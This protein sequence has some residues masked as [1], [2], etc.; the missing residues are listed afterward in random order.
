MPLKPIRVTANLPG[1]VEAAVIERIRE[2][3][4]PSVSAY[5]VGLV[6]FDL[7]SRRPHLMTSTLMREPQWLRDQAIAELVEAF[8]NG[9]KGG[10]GWF[11]KRIDEL[12][13]ER[14]AKGESGADS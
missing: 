11:E 2:E 14:K 12:I 13:E 4:Y 6:L 5:I 3:K 8:H 1:E 7:Y 9:G 10:L